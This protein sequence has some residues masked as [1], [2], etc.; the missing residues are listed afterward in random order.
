MFVLSLLSLFLSFLKISIIQSLS[1]I[2]SICPG[3]FNLIQIIVRAMRACAI[4]TC[5]FMVSTV[6]EHKTCI[7]FFCV[8]LR[9]VQQLFSVNL[10][11]RFLKILCSL[12][13]HLSVLNV[14]SADGINR[15]G[16]FRSREL[17]KLS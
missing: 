3:N 9:L 17:I 8:N 5:F 4:K 13:S 16:A 7:D 6:S 2:Y 12:L 1:M 14:S 10:I 15:N 11:F